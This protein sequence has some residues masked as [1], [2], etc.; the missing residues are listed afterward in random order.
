[1]AKCLGAGVIASCG[2]DEKTALCRQLGADEVINYRTE[3]MAARIKAFAPDGVDVMWETARVPDFDFAVGVLRRRGRFI[4]MAGRD[5][6][7][8]LPVGPFYTKGLSLFGFIMFLEPLDVLARAAADI[9][10]WMAAGRLK[11]R[12]DRVL[13]FSRAAEAHRLQEDATLHG[14][15]Q[16]AGKIVLV[17]E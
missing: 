15:G 5:A 4:L 12:I 9:N 1:M 17:P 2:S 10:R 6:R 16:V 11:A 8:V 13:P 14:S 3:D 7:Q